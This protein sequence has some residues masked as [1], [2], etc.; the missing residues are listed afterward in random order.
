MSNESA[1]VLAP[2][3]SRAERLAGYDYVLEVSVGDPRE[4]DPNVLSA[5][6]YNKKEF[7]VNAAIRAGDAGYYASLYAKD[8]ECIYERNP[9]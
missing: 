9:A 2:G 4:D 6:G 7:A 3:L 1:E 8:G 5:R